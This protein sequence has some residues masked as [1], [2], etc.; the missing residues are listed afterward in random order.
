MSRKT[1]D[2]DSSSTTIQRFCIKTRLP[3]RRHVAK[4]PRKRLL[5]RIRPT[6]DGLSRFLPLD[7][8]IPLSRKSCSAVSLT[9]YV[10]RDERVRPLS[11]LE[12]LSFIK[13]S[14]LS[15]QSLFRC[16]FL[17]VVRKSPMTIPTNIA[18]SDLLVRETP[19]YPL[20]RSLSEHRRE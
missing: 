1:L 14:S 12:E 18:C 6:E 7:P 16:P 8:N 4:L 2:V 15:V 10:L 11:R 20:R 5:R 3:G 17:P 13:S 9:R 19:S